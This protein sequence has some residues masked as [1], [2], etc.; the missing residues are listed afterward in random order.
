MGD[1]C[2]MHHHGYSFIYRNLQHTPQDINVS[3]KK[4]GAALQNRRNKEKLIETSFCLIP[5]AGTDCHGG[6]AAT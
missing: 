3:L 2:V 6:M 1:I 4:A 5:E